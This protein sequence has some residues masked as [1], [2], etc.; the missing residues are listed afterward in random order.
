MCLHLCRVGRF[1]NYSLLASWNST[2]QLLGQYRNLLDIQHHFLP[3][4]S[5][6]Y[7][8]RPV[9]RINA[10]GSQ[11]PM[12]SAS[13]I[14]KASEPSRVE[15]LPR[16][17]MLNR[18]LIGKKLKVKV[19]EGEFRGKEVVLIPS[20]NEA[21]KGQRLVDEKESVVLRWKRFS[22]WVE[23]EPEWVSVLHPNVT[24]GNGLLIVVAGE[25]CGKYVRR[26]DHRYDPTNMDP[27]IFVAVVNHGPDLADTLTGETFETRPTYLCIS[28]E[29]K[30]ERDRNQ[31]LM[32]PLREQHRKRRVR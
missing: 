4:K 12:N 5:P 31:S 14:T 10:S 9:E 16:L 21:K 23:M 17:W 29:T 19:T 20:F 2:G 6:R 28:D 25:H 24:L 22:S 13:P 11:S 32:V 15:E 1:A 27:Y 7:I 18:N 30:A 8:A 26:Y 3:L